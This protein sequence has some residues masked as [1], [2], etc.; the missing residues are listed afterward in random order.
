MLDIKIKY[1]LDIKPIE[2]S[3]TGDWIDL[4]AG[5]DI[6][7]EQFEYAQIPLGVCMQIPKGYTAIIAPRSSTFKK[8]GIIQVN[9]IGV[10]DESYC[11]DNDQWC[12][13]VMAMRRTK[14]YKNDRI[15]Q[16]RLIKKTESIDFTRVKILDNKD[17]GGFG[18]TGVN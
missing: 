17:R 3:D 16:F 1:V 18:S 6:E 4:R 12:L 11:G 7:L 9:S 15:C 10:I 8:W 14:I 13:P 5:K 2:V